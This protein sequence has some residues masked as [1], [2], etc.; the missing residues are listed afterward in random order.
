MWVF[1]GSNPLTDKPFT[2]SAVAK[3][4]GIG[5]ET[6]RYYQRI[7]LIIEPVKPDTGYRVYPDDTVSRLYFIQRAKELGFSL[8]EIASLLELGDGQCSEAR[9]L[10]QEKLLIIRSKIKDLDAIAITLENLIH[11][12]DNN[13]KHQGCPIINTISHNK[14]P[15]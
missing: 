14:K 5:V 9:E 7:G 11:S 4:L 1:S 6:I 8:A 3:K 12:C 15:A 10:A 2:I 13:P